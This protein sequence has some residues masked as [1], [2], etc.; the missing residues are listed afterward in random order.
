VKKHTK[1]K[2]KLTAETNQQ[3][4]AERKQSTTAEKLQKYNTAVGKHN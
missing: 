3:D 1:K 2:T 4:S